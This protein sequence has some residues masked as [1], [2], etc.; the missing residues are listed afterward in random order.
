MS[1]T[2]LAA[3][4]V[5]ALSVFIYVAPQVAF[6]GMSDTLKMLDTDSDG[7]VSLDEAQA[8]G[9]KKFADMDPDN[10][11]TIDAKEA[12][13]L[14]KKMFK[15]GDPDKDGTIDKAEFSA[16]VEEAFKKADTDGDGTLD[17]KELKSP[18]GK[19]LRKLLK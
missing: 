7:T 12:K 13:G 10:D 18:A 19:K 6:A 3:A 9:A 16:L 5:M 8:A 17:K 15:M 4:S 1:F 2:K 14:P 11:G